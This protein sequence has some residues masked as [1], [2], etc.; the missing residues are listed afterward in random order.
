[1]GDAATLRG[2]PAWEGWLDWADDAGFAP[3]GTRKEEL[4]EQMDLLLLTRCCTRILLRPM[5]RRCVRT[6]ACCCLLWKDCLL[7]R[8]RLNPV[9]P[10]RDAPQ[11]PPRLA[12]Q[13]IAVRP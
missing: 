12:G 7:G 1:M 6:R 3:T 2:C 11:P 10:D 5:L 4:A 8:W 13:R 9:A